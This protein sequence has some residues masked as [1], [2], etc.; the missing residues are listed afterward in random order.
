MKQGLLEIIFVIDRSGS[1][2]KIKKNMIGGFN[3]FIAEQK[4]VKVGE[5]KVS[6]YQFDTPQQGGTT[7][8]FPQPIFEFIDLDL[9]PDLTEANYTPRGGTALNDAFAMTIKN[10]GARLANTPE[11]LRPEKVMVITITD[12]EENSSHEYTG[13]QVK[14]MIEEQTKTYN[15]SFTYMGANQDAWSV[16]SSYGVAG[17]STLTFGTSS[18]AMSASYSSLS[19]N[20]INYRSNYAVSGSAYLCNSLCFSD[21]DREVQK[22]AG[23]Y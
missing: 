4:S 9:V 3:S 13:A 21:A 14:E 15:W 16:G 23:A 8:A 17:S 11:E 22:A 18:L 2:D 20:M 7:E 10:V 12:G 1:M 6:A 19:A 5:V